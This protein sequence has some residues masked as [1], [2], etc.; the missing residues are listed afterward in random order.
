MGA[1]LNPG[2]G[3]SSFDVGAFGS[4]GGG[5]GWNISGDLFVGVVR[6]DFS[7]IRGDTYNV[8]VGIGAASISVMFDPC[9]LDFVGFTFGPGVF[10][11]FPFGVSG[12]Y[13]RTDAWS[14]IK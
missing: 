2:F 12:T 8:N 1:A 7:D 4:I 14:F 13:S 10:G 11:P 3:D 5:A 9:S 6:G